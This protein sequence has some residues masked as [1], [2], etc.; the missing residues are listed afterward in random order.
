[1]RAILKWFAI[2][3]VI[4]L[5]ALLLY[6]NHGVLLEQRTFLLVSEDVFGFNYGS[7]EL[8][9][10]IYFLGCLVAGALFMAIPALGLVWKVRKLKKQLARCQADNEDP[11]PEP[12]ETG[13]DLAYQID[14]DQGLD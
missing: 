3:I 7:A 10:L 9:L 11:L 14:D 12:E 13:V 5:G 2:L 1:M 8:P 6:Q 4:I